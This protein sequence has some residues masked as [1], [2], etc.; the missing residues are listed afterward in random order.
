MSETTTPTPPTTRDARP[1]QT[2][3][4]LANGATVLQSRHAPHYDLNTVIVLALSR[5]EFVTW[6]G[7]LDGTGTCWGHYFDQD[8]AAALDDYNNR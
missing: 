4:R 7:N 1:V 6:V 8:L 3:S 2:G 5:D